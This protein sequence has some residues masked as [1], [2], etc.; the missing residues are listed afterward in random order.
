MVGRECRSVLRIDD[1]TISGDGYVSRRLEPG[2][3]LALLRAIDKLDLAYLRTHPF[4]GMC[5]TAYDGSES[6]YRFS[7]FATLLPACTYD[8]RRVE[9][10]RLVEKLLRT[11]KPVRR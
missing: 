4:E 8:L 5:P 1:V 6:I 2:E 3:R 11:L 10:V 9:A 7:G